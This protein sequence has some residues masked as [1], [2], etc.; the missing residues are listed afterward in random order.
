MAKNNKFT[1]SAPAPDKQNGTGDYD[2]FKAIG[3]RSKFG[4]LSALVG[5]Q[6]LAV[7][8]LFVWV[9]VM[10]LM[11]PSFKHDWTRFWSIKYGRTEQ[12]QK[13]IPYL[14]TLREN[15]LNEAKIQAKLDRIT[16][17]EK[18]MDNPTYCYE[19]GNINMK[20]GNFDKG[21]DWFTRAQACRKNTSSD[22]TGKKLPA[23]DFNTDIGI[24]YFRLKQ[25]DKAEG[26]FNA[27]LSFNPLDTVAQ[28]YIGEVEM[29]KGNYSAAIERFKIAAGNPDYKARV[30][31]NYKIIEQK[32]LTS[33]KAEEPTS[34]TLT[35]AGS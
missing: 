25:Y 3:A 20:L 13:A 33:A 15:A 23:Y 4:S 2:P 31:D 6:S 8:F 21:L 1:N 22:D 28:Y 5:W 14:M 16:Y 10:Y 32:L 18:T 7:V 35:T 34:G 19:L 24:A 26:A 12:P 11:A 29:A 17:D 27:A 30:L 9:V